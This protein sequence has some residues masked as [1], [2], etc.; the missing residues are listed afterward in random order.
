MR[1]A[2]KMPATMCL[3]SSLFSAS[4]G[5]PLTVTT[6]QNTRIALPSPTLSKDVLKGIACSPDGIPWDVGRMPITKM[7]SINTEIKHREKI[8][9]H[10]FPVSALVARPVPKSEVKAKL[11]GGDR[12]P[13]D[14]LD[15]EWSSLRD[16]SCWDEENVVEFTN[17]S[18]K[19]GF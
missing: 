1:G 6:Q 17:L 3:L 11:A 16:D 13:Q 12:G 9:D 4:F 19:G 15:E 10:N 7:P 2:S 5:E 14:A 18:K 8:P